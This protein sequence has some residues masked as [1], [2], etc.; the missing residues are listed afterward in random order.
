[1]ISRTI[2]LFTILFFI[3]ISCDTAYSQ[4]VEKQKII[5]DGKTYYLHVVKKGEGFYRLSKDYGV[6]QK[7]IIDANPEIVNGLKVG[8]VIHIPFIKGRTDNSK[9]SNDFVYHTV[10]HGQT[11]YYLS[12]KYKVSIDDIIINN[13]GVDKALVQGAILKIPVKKQKVLVED[14]YAYHNVKSKETL[15]G[16]SKTYHTS[17]DS[18][19]ILNPALKSGVLS[20]NSRIRVPLIKDKDVKTTSVVDKDL[21][22]EDEEY[23]YHSIK[24]S[25]TFNGVCNIYNADKRSVELSNQG[26]DTNNLQSGYI[27]RI[28]KSA[29]KKA[30]PLPLNK[31]S[32]EYTI[33]NVRRKETLYSISNKYG[34][35][36]NE[37][38]EIND[39]QLASLKKG[40]KIKIPTQEYL[41]DQK[42]KSEE[43]KKDI[44]KRKRINYTDTI[45][46]DCLVE[47]KNNFDETLTVALL[48]PFDI[49]ST[50]K[51]NIVTKV[52]DEEEVEVPREK[53]IVS[54]R[55]RT[56]IEFYEGALMA[57]DSLKKQGV[58][59]H[60]LTYDTAPDT[61]R[62]K[63]ILAQP[64][65]QL[66][67]LIIGPAFAS[68]LHLVS[69]FSAN[70][71]IHMVYPLS[72]MNEEIEQNPFMFQVNP[73]DSVF[74]DQYS[75]YIVN[76]SDTARLVVVSSSKPS[77]DEKKLTHM[78]KQK[79]YLRAMQ[80]GKQPD[81]MQIPFSTKDIQGVA[82]LLSSDKKN[83]VVVPSTKE[84]DVSKI[85]TTLKG[86]KETTK[87]EVKLIGFNKW[88]RFQ[89]INPEDIFELD[90][91]VLTTQSINYDDDAT[92]EYIKKYRNWYHTEP[93]A[94]AP[95]FV[96]SGSN[97][98]YS[99]YG[100]W[101]FDVA[102]YF[103]SARAQYGPKFEY[104]LD[105]IKAEQIQ[106]N[107]NFKRSENW[108]GFYNSGLTL[109]KFEP[110]FNVK[111]EKL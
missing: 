97:S 1:M 5:I 26:I 71:H 44:V 76:M 19:I 51:A 83:I 25:D 52:V 48:L 12:K 2:Q 39:S 99:R 95:Y 27:L 64:E 18:L 17:V 30:V 53:P 89:T 73:S 100:T 65:M 11:L 31:R 23:I 33:H 42:L 57:L 70:N 41:N 104:C 50:K 28:P 74:F 4:N 85:V 7:E 105:D 109:I 54:S 82:A 59:I 15:Y 9:D 8:E 101:G 10:E 3:L 60:L 21:K 98:N 66:A 47:Y 111:V 36:I 75:D 63:E 6:S 55:S 78:I 106:F 87:C 79:S 84:A 13:R 110:D 77:D 22:I 90:T 24:Q 38:K 103:V 14:G 102:Y 29:I 107:F 72:S 35:T 68:N 16:I 46:V 69:E 96:R 49:E 45:T 67:D 58:K 34:V 32:S 88:L 92:Q 61:N 86:V 94:V 20:V 81:F 43:V 37:I 93:Y 91:E 108:S 56:F 40:Q 80:H 62:V